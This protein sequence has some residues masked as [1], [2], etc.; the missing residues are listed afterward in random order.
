MRQRI[1]DQIDQI[2]YELGMGKKGLICYE[3]ELLQHHVERA[4]RQIKE[5]DIDIQHESDKRS[6]VQINPTADATGSRMMKEL[7]TERE[8]S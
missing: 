8:I 1:L 4:L 7:S 5:L 6:P 2:I 3:G